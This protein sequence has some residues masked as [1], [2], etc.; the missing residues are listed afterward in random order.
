MGVWNESN[1]K[2][3]EDKFIT[4]RTLIGRMMWMVVV[5]VRAMDYSSEGFT[6]RF[7]IDPQT[8]FNG[9]WYLKQLLMA[10]SITIWK[11]NGMGYIPIKA[12]ESMKI[13]V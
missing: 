1:H 9:F 11:E 10:C 5:A 13:A 8:I 12:E 3:F 2:D 7:S 6:D 4:I